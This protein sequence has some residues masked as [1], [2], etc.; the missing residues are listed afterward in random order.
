MVER[1][2]GLKYLGDLLLGVPELIWLQAEY[3][4]LR[5]QAIQ[6][7]MAECGWIG[8]WWAYGE[9][10]FGWTVYDRD[11]DGVLRMRTL[12][13]AL[14]LDRPELWGK[15]SR[16]AGVV[17]SGEFLDVPFENDAPLAV[18][19]PDDATWYSLVVSPVEVVFAE[20][21]LTVTTGSA[22]LAG[23]G[24]DFT[25]F[26]GKTT[27]SIPRGL[28]M[29]IDP[30]D[31]ASGNEG[32]YEFDTITDPETATL[33]TPI[34]GTDESGVRFRITGDY[35]GA[36]PADP[37]IGI[38]VEPLWELVP[39]TPTRPVGKLFVMDVMRDTG[40]LPPAII[41][42]RRHSNI[43]RSISTLHPQFRG[44]TARPTQRI[45]PIVHGYSLGYNTVFDDANDVFDTSIAPSI[46]GK[47]LAVIVENGDLHFRE[48]DPNINHDRQFDI[49][50]IDDQN[51]ETIGVEITGDAGR[52]GIVDMPVLPLF[53]AATHMLVYTEGAIPPFVLEMRTT[54]DHGVS[55]SGAQVIWNPTLVDPA[56][57]LFS[58]DIIVTR[59][60]R[61]IVCATYVDDSEGSHGQLR[62]IFSDDY[63][64]TWDTN[65]NAGYK[66]LDN[67]ANDGADNCSLAQDDGGS[68]W[69]A[70]ELG[71]NDGIKL[72]R[73]AT[74]ETLD[75]TGGPDGGS[76][77]SHGTTIS[78]VAPDGGSA[79]NGVHSPALW[80]APDGT[81]LCFYNQNYT[82]G[83][84]FT[85]NQS[86]YMVCA[87]REK[88]L[89]NKRLVIVEIGAGT[90]D[91][92]LSQSVAQGI[93]GALHLL[94]TDSA[95]AQLNC[96]SVVLYPE[97]LHRTI[98]TA[99]DFLPP[100]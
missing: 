8:R 81:V 36:I 65:G 35:F 85:R 9:Q 88:V 57:S 12:E 37:D 78:L 47:M 66:C 98:R 1:G 30:A 60:N 50:S 61:I 89:Y 21:T 15:P 100:P 91:I 28:K 95:A 32:T 43:Y 54:A 45:T 71:D 24:T 20:G 39:R 44:Y 82:T 6:A 17:D 10:G 5:K 4:E 23:V 93:N 68:I 7:N 97:P 14:S 90:S 72:F 41:I 70:Y 18:T 11:G 34:N 13:T 46:D 92:S 3:S 22:T 67:A 49:G 64:T 96:R 84:G 33:T 25:R 58:P 48:W 29:R 53:G 80:A 69:C 42:D 19:V 74:P 79:P 31:T 94:W 99:G 87:N 62:F 52:C 83:G 51:W 16:F 38:H 86:V 27:D 55:W 26:A 73:G 63:G 56:D 40:A 77:T 2:R 59:G 76:N 75:R